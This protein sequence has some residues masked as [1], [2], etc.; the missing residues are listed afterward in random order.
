V[1]DRSTVPFRRASSERRWVERP[2]V[3]EVLDQ[4][5][6]GGVGLV[7]APAGSGKSVAM[8]QWA[9]LGDLGVGWLDLTP[10]HNDTVVFAHALVESL[11]R[12][13]PAFDSSV[14][15]LVSHDGTSVGRSFRD[16]VV[17]EIAAVPSDVVL[18]LDDAHQ[19]TGRALSDDLAD[20]LFRLPANAR[21]VVGSRWDP[22]FA[23][24]GLWLAEPVELRA[25]DLAFDQSEAV[26]LI[27][28]VAGQPISPPQAAM[29]VDRTDGWAAGLQLAA[30]SMQRTHDQQLFVDTFAGDDRMVADYLTEEVIRQQSD[31]VRRFLL[32]TSVLD[33]L[34]PDLCDAVT[35]DANATAML[36]DLERRCVFIVPVDGSDR[37]RF[38]YHHLFADLLRYRLRLD[39][40]G[41]EARLRSKAAAWLA[42]H[43]EVADAVEQLLAAQDWH[44]ALDLIGSRGHR[45]YERGASGRLVDWLTRIDTEQPATPVVLINLLAAQM[46]ADHFTAADETYRQLSRIDDL[47]TGERVASE[48]LRSMGGIADLPSD[49]VR[50]A[51]QNVLDELPH[52]D[53]TSVVDFLGIGGTASMEV[54]VHFMSAVADFWDAEP[55]AAAGRLRTTLELPGATYPD[56]RINIL[57]GL[58]LTLAWQGQLDESQRLAA[59][60]IRTA[61]DKGTPHHLS[62]TF[63]HLAL[64]MTNLDRLDL[65]TADLHLDEA[66]QSSERSRRIAYLHLWHR[67]HA[68]LVERTAGAESALAVLRSD[69]PS[70]VERPA[71]ADARRGHE[72]RMLLA[73]GATTD[74]AVVLD[75]CLR[76]PSAPR[77]DL[78][79][80]QGDLAGAA[81]ITDTWTPDTGDV[82][83]AIERDI[84]LAILADRI[85][86][87]GRAG[88]LLAETLER[89][90]VEQLRRPFVEC[91]AAIGLLQ[92]ATPRRRAH[93]HD[94]ILQAS[95]ISPQRSANE[96]LIDPL[97]ERERSVLDYLPT[98]LTNQEIADTLYISVNTLKTHLR[99]IYRKL[100]VAD[101]NTA[102]AEASRLGLL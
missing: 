95:A 63:A 39:E 45:L 80:A 32:R 37:S 101:R 78:C 7:V 92:R 96:G 24:G 74:A 60:A 26:E 20:L 11:C 65:A 6:P 27:E 75:R 98:R 69:L 3:H 79:L 48:A 53:D 82:R 12:A 51:A 13:H 52:L 5:K 10:A 23:A 100:A 89:A 97:S 71:L 31:E 30:L 44:G 46:G 67:V 91:P 15:T 93:F 33:W 58:A 72:V 64:A 55:G 87:S 19:L 56:S 17:G 54:I 9:M 61:H 36:D 84:R 21:G 16:A 81:A 43:G 90:E 86:R 35:G 1:T 73:V 41:L 94:S 25:T 14:L 22:L 4:V 99:N 2:R 8:A 85:S 83:A 42:T 62:V 102:V 50:H 49:Q 59:T 66:A 76:P 40:P 68:A 77:I 29:L 88:T 47:A 38:R 34:T 70:G 28:S 18:I 57:G